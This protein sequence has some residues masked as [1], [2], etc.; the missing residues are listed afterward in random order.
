MD[1]GRSKK[2]RAWALVWVGAGLSLGVYALAAWCL[3]DYT[4]GWQMGLAALILLAAPP[5]V[6]WMLRRG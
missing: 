2:R 5:L 1:A 6:W 3:A 4:G